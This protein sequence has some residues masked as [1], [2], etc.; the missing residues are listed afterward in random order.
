L[1]GDGGKPISREC[2]QGLSSATRRTQRLYEGRAGVERQANYAVG[3]VHSNE[4]AQEQAWEHGRAVFPF[5]DSRGM[6]GKAGQM[7]LARQLP[8]SYDGPHD[9]LS[10]SYQRQMNRRLADLLDEGITG[11]GA[12][13]ANL[14]VE[15]SADRGE[16]GGRRRPVYYR[17]GS[18]AA[19]AFNRSPE[20]ERFWRGRIR[21]RRFAIWHILGGSTREKSRP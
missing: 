21:R 19:R 9:I 14:P 16:N 10:R 17:D 6:V 12:D 11:N 8:N 2:L 15:E 1:A 13:A 4:E 5:Q 18:K 20:E 3:R 7:Y